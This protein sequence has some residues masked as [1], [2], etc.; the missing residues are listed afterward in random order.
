MD[1]ESINI[2]CCERR[3]LLSLQE[4]SVCFI[5][6]V[7]LI[8]GFLMKQFLWANCIQLC[9]IFAHPVIGQSIPHLRV[10]SFK[11]FRYPKTVNSTLLLWFFKYFSQTSNKQ[12]RSSVTNPGRWSTLHRK[13]NPR[14]LMLYQ[15]SRNFLYYGKLLYSMCH[16]QQVSQVENDL[17]DDI[18]IFLVEH[19]AQILQQICRIFKQTRCCG[20]AFRLAE[21]SKHRWT[22][23]A[24]V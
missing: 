11:E 13:G 10:Q 23:T 15:K 18:W 17:A 7:A 3:C 21:A 1:E 6:I 4:W 8:W 9:K 2:I 12:V 24:L 16:L 22:V 19:G 14:N 5:P 20:R